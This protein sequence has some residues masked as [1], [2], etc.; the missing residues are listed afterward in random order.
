MMGLVAAWASL[1][2]ETWVGSVFPPPGTL[3]VQPIDHCG[4]VNGAASKALA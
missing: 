4:L 1:N 2:L 3:C